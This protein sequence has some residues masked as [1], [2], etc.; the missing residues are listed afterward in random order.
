MPTEYQIDPKTYDVEKHYQELEHKIAAS[1]NSID[2][3]RVRAAFEVAERAHAG[4]KRKDGT[5]YVSHCVA[6]SIIATE[7]GLDEDSI[8]AS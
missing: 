7:M 1:G 2:L 3:N 8:V 5:P 6:A 4:Q